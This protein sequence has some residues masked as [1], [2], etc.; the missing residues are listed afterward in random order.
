MSWALTRLGSYEKFS[1]V[2]IDLIECCNTLH[3]K[4]RQSGH[5]FLAVVLLMKTQDEHGSGN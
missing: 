5:T 4:G 1:I 2:Q 3:K